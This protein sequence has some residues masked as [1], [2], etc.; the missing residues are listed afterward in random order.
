MFRMRIHRQ[1]LLLLLL[2]LAAT[3]S[4]RAQQLSYGINPTLD[5][6]AFERFR[7]HMDSIRTHRPTVALVLSGGGAKGAAH[8]SIIRYL[9]SADIPVDLVLGTSIG[10]LVGGLYACG[11]SGSELEDIIRSQ[12]W[13]YLM[14]DTH[15]RRYDALIQKDFDRQYQLSIPFGAYQWDF[16]GNDQRTERS[17][18][19]LLSNGIVQGRNIENLFS[20]LLVGFGDEQDFLRL[21]IPFV[22]VATDMVTAQP[23]VWHSG[24]LV[25]AL[26]STM[27]IPGLFT[28]I[29]TNG[30]VL[31]DGSLRNNMPASIARQLGAD[32]IITVDISAPALNA[33]QIN[34][35]V[36]FIF[37][38]TDVLGRESYLAALATTDIYIQPD[39]TDYSLLSFDAQSIDSIL[40][41]GRQAVLAH[42]DEIAVLKELI[43][44]T[45][46]YQNAKKAVNMRSRP[47]V[48]EK[49]VFKGI[50]DEEEAYLRQ[51]LRLHTVLLKHSVDDAVATM[52]GTKAFEKVTYEL[53]GNESPYTLQFNCFRSPI[54]QLD[55]GARF[56]AYDFASLQL[57]AGFNANRLMG[58]RLDLTA[59][60][61]LKSS[62]S[63]GYTYRT[64]KGVDFCAEGSFQAIRNGAFRSEPYDFRIDFNRTR[65]DGYV[66]F[67]PW[68]Q[69]YLQ[70]GVR[71]DYFY[72]VSMLVDYGLTSG[73]WSDIG[74]S[75]IYASA[76]ARL[77]YD[78]FD[79][80]Y[81]PRQGMLYNFHYNVYLPGW[82]QRTP[83]LHAFHLNYKAALS[84]G[85]L[86]LLPFLEVRHI[87]DDVVPYI[88][89]LSISDANKSLDQ[90][91]SFIGIST[92]VASERMLGTLGLS[93]RFQAYSKHYLTATLQ[94]LQE[95]DNI[96]TFFDGGQSN[97][98]V[99]VALEYAYRTIIGPVKANIHWSDLNKSVGFYLGLGYE[100]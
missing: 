51:Q 53:L 19:S 40:A 25:D 35:L 2:L 13:N 1:G 74:K 26:R 20:S 31:V 52:I 70:T 91:I 14:R 68:K 21:P 72:R 63:V 61:G 22:C 92:P 76:F 34:S 9:E 99:G 64:G 16:L 65:F 55:G 42:A 71:M 32:I 3:A 78:S 7:Q 96:R 86:T 45:M 15:P 81:F 27:S 56:D 44:D 5:S 28:P 43:G 29:K 36:D 57:H 37:Q 73:T 30:M 85:R 39:M 89:M 10:G 67:L 62:L 38:T 98:Y 17:N 24:R 66:S 94:L 58:S 84:K 87:S 12:D 69:L 60:L 59:R 82:F 79:E 77:R 33:K 8:V 11:Y 83:T 93:A 88:N 46:T 23:K 41:R 49:I 90:Q 6:M 97:T 95:S 48:T 75:N 50:N 18:R 47:V 54:N 100:F 80:P 4:L